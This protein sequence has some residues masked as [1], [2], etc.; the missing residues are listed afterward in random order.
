MTIDDVAS[1][2]AE[3]K[4]KNL[5]KLGFE[6]ELGE[7]DVTMY[8]ITTKE[9]YVFE[10]EEEADNQINEARQNVGFAAAT[11]KYKAGKLSKTG[12]E[13]RPET[14]TVVIKLNH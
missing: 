7:D 5:T 12:D 6:T 10:N 11:K 8:V 14:W 13:V 3:R 1:Y 9:T 2:A 4:E